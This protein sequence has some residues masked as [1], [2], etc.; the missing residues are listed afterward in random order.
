MATEFTRDQLVG[1]AKD[2]FKA[3]LKRLLQTQPMTDGEL[4]DALRCTPAMA[5]LCIKELKNQK[6]RIGL[7]PDNRYFVHVSDP[8]GHYVI[9]NPTGRLKLGFTT[10]NHLANVHARMDVLHAAYDDFARRGVRYVLNAGNMIEGVARFNKQELRAHTFGGQLELWVN[11][12]PVRKG[13]VTLF[14]TG[15]DHEGWWAQREVINV[16]EVMQQHA[17]KVGRNDLVYVGHVESDIEL[18]FKGKSCPARLM[19]P[20]GGA[21]Y[22]LSY[23]SQKIVEAF[24]GGEKPAIVFGGHY[25]KFDYCY[26]REVYF[27][28]GGCTCDQTIFLRKN[29]IGVH[30]GYTNIELEQDEKDGHLTEVLVGWK[31]SY[32]RGYYERRFD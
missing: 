27:I 10:D 7:G 21:A 8:G 13:I 18:R 22:A 26:P 19:H 30:V 24:Q 11:E 29:K 14:V 1:A 32:D 31:P 9:E 15:D 17:H 2:K 23:T 4:A 5:R 20:G 16:G 28:Q 3:E 6:T 25:H 12:W